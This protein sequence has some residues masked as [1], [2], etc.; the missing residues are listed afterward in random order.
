VSHQLV[1]HAPMPVVVIPPENRKV[2]TTVPTAS[3]PASV[4]AP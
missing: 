4:A 2:T 3:E 1:L